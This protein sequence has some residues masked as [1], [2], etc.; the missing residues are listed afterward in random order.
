MNSRFRLAPFHG[1]AGFGLIFLLWG[2]IDSGGHE[3]GWTH[4]SL[5]ITEGSWFLGQREH[6][7]VYSRMTVT[8][9]RWTT[10]IGPESLVLRRT[11]MPAEKPFCRGPEAFDRDGRWG[12]LNIHREEISV[13]Y[14]IILPAYLLLWGGAAF[15]RSKWKQRAERRASSVAVQPE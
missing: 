13:P 14:C 8:P 4:I 5:R 11:A 12:S 3:S 7:L 1:I 9:D 15:A 2:A 10:V 6:A